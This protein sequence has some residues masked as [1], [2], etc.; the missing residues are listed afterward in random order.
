MGEREANSV[1]SVQ[2]SHWLEKEDGRVNT[3]AP[4][5]LSNASFD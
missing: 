5:Y 1:L 4:V 2:L 3:V